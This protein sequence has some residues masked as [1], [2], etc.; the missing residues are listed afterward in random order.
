MNL[1][2]QNG[3]LGALGDSGIIIGDLG[4]G[5][6]GLF[7]LPQWTDLDVCPWESYGCVSNHLPPNELSYVEYR[8]SNLLRVGTLYGLLL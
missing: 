2:D 6:D 8:G 4:G 3:G 7:S 1:G 5:P